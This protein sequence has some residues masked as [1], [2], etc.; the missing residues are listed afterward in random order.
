MP[1]QRRFW[2]RKSPST[3]ISVFIE[4]YFLLKTEWS[5]YILMRIDLSG[6]MNSYSN[7]RTPSQ[8]KYYLIDYLLN[9]LQII[10][11]IYLIFSAWLNEH[12][13][14]IKISFFISLFIKKNVL[15]F[16]RYSMSIDF[17]KFWKSDVICF[18]YA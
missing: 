12:V 13:K 3:W 11:M 9:S 1:H 4:S 6:G 14:R 8:L 17:L 18:F 10:L 15:L 16:Q 7:L 2:Y 5:F